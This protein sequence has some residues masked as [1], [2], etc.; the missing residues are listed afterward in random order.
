MQSWTNKGSEI[1]DER[2][3]IRWSNGDLAADFGTE[4]SET[5]I[6]E[7]PADRKMWLFV[8]SL[9]SDEEGYYR[10]GV[11]LGEDGSA[12]M[13]TGWCAM[14]YGWSNDGSGWDGMDNTYDGLSCFERTT[15]AVSYTHL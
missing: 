6:Y 10:T 15:K 7:V 1:T 3:D 5:G 11:T 2:F 8:D 13:T 4:N 14:W 12:E 9:K